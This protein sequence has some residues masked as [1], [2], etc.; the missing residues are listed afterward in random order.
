MRAGA[1]PAASGLDELTAL[2]RRVQGG[3]HMQV[4]SPG[5]RRAGDT[6]WRGVK[7][8]VLLEA[9]TLDETLMN[10][11]RKEPKN[12]ALSPQHLESGRRGDPEPEG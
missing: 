2:P 1:E 5:D 8:T 3:H 9:V 12:K 6:V 4:C 11:H 7:R 10:R